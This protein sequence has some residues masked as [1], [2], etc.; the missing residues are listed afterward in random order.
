MSHYNYNSD[1][2]HLIL[3]GIRLQDFGKDS[4]FKIVWDNDS[5][6]LQNGV[7]GSTTTSERLE[8]SATITFKIQQASPLNFILERLSKKKGFPV[9]Y[10]NADYVGDVGYKGEDA[11]IPKIAD[12]EVNGDSS[13][14]EWTV[15]VPNM[16]STVDVAEDLL[17]GFGG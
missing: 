8:K 2:H 5:K 10:V 9:L 12:L 14:R 4:K 3:G 16:V 7:D 15:R 6:T 11:F 17:K 13:E 1:N